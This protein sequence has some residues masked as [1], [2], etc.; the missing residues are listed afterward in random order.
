MRV[1]RLRVQSLLVLGF[2][3]LPSPSTEVGLAQE[4]LAA[5]HPRLFFT[6]EERDR[7]WENRDRG[8]RPLIWKNLAESAEWCLTK[9]PREEWIEPLADDPIYENLYDRFY[10]MMMDMSIIEHLAFAYALSGEEKYG[11]AAREWTLSCSKAWKPDS[12]ATPDGG[13]AYAVSRLLKGIA[14]SYDLVH[15][16]FSQKERDEI[17]EM[18]ATTASNYYENYFTTETI[19]GPGFHTHHAIVEFSSF[20]IVALTLLDEVPEA[21]KWL[22]TVIEK[23]ESHLL[24]TGLAPDGAQTEGATFWASTMHY[25]LFFMDALR[26]VTGRDMFEEFAEF[27]NADLALASIA[28]TKEAG[29]NEPNQTVVLEPPYGQ[30]DYYSPILLCLAREYRRP[31]Y[32]HLALWDR[33]LGHIQKTRY[34]TPNRKEQLLFEFGGYAFAWYD[35][36]VPDEPIE[37]P[38]SYQFDSV[39]QAYMRGSWDPKGLL[40]AADRGGQVIVHAGGIPVVMAPGIIKATAE[41][42]YAATIIRDDGAVCKMAW[43]TDEDAQIQ[44]KLTRPDSVQLRWINVKEPLVFRSHRT[45]STV[46]RHLTWRGGTQLSVV[47]GSLDR[48]EP[49]AYEVQFAVGN[50]KLDLIDPAPRKYPEIYLNPSDDHEIEILIETKNP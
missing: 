1:N 5:D 23:F 44:V 12:E 28:T 6:E 24:P 34:I 30:L 4:S 35:A 47:N 2:I 37:A 11:E 27:M 13:K 41:S 43:G 39:G 8:I 21:S 19:L 18:L 9:S 45:P 33:S 3:V 32:Q 14:T 22:E 48:L 36:A 49:N 7:L 46:A 20:G 17:R 16:R 15:D 31:L 26:R 42:P 25:R 10:A 40:I 38:L 29:W 50:G